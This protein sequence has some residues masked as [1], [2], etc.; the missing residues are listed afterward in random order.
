MF[1][2]NI[3][4]LSYILLKGCCR[5]CSA[6]ISFKYFFIELLCAV[7]TLFLFNFFYLNQQS[8]TLFFIALF[9][10]L[11]LVSIIFIDL[12]VMIIPDALSLGGLLIA[13]LLSFI[14][15]DWHTFLSQSSTIFTHLIGLKKAFYGMIV[16]GGIILLIGIIGSYIFKKEAMGG[17]DVKM[18]AMVGA[19]LGAPSIWLILFLASLLGTAFALLCILKGSKKLSDKVPFGPY[20]AIASFIALCWKN[21]IYHWFFYG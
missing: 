15:P 17:G 14:F 8:L 5:H 3:P 2:D 20:L 16:G 12:K 21:N 11:I 13:L 1:Y 9:F 10:S 19:F 7:L 18:M 6:K 4:L